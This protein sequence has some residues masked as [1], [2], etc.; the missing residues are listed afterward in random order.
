MGLVLLS[1]YPSILLSNPWAVLSL[2]KLEFAAW[3]F[4]VE[5]RGRLS[6]L[7]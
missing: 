1:L 4:L 2:P 6:S 7:R 5:A 3:G